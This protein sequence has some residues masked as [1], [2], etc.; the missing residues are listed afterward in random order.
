MDE[1]DCS[2]FMHNGERMKYIRHEVVHD[3]PLCPFMRQG[4]YHHDILIL[5]IYGERELEICLVRLE[6]R[7]LERLDLLPST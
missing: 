3:S 5:S 7:Y 6:A 4:R 2:C 1:L